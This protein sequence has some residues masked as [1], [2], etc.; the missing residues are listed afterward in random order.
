VKLPDQHAAAQ[1]PRRRGIVFGEI[2]FGEPSA[3]GE[4][5]KMA[6]RRFQ[7]P[8][9]KREGNFWYLLVWQD[10]FSQG[11]RTR[12][13]KR[14]KLAPTTMPEREVKKVAAEIATAQSGLDHRRLGDAVWRIRGGNLHAHRA[15]S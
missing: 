10:E 4:F 13:R 3:K 1:H 11:R 14:V 8:E 5:E 2:N 15:S 12:K 9:P 7:D 6:R